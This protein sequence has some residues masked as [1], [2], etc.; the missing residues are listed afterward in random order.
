MHF[1]DIKV[2]DVRRETDECVS[3]AFD[4]PAEL[5]DIFKFE[6]GQNITIRKDINGEELRRS[7]SICTSPTDH[8]IRVAIKAVDGGRFSSWANS[9]LKPGD[10]L[11]LMPPTGRFNTRLDPSSR[12]KYLAFAAGSG[13]TPI[14]SI[15]KTTLQTEPQSS[16]TLVY[17]NRYRRSIIFREE[18]ESLK[19]KYLDRFQLIHILSRE[20]PENEVLFGR[21]DAAKC[22]QLCGQL[23]D[24]EHY[25]HAFLCG[26]ENMIFSVR[27][28]LLEQGF[29]KENIHYELFTAPGSTGKT[30][31]YNR[32]TT[33]QQAHIKV[34]IDG[35]IT[36]FDLPA[37]GD[38][39]LNAAL[40]HGADLPFACKG[41]VCSTCRARLVEGK[42]EM[43][44]NYALEQEEV[45]AGFILTCQS[46]PVTETVFVDFDQR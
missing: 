10:T 40:K 19:N 39:I 42:V 21:I 20:E 22:S 16:F 11:E 18:L 35:I 8:E 33:G 32:N 9:H 24:P 14:I 45:D 34:K 3:V 41:G 46:H 36:H 5:K 27:D 6:Q 25:H 23:L 7:Y 31:M 37:Q 26:P 38:T 17:G 1:Y 13:I 43:D 44:V 15:I 28:Y 12:K 4:I 30:E 2:K 29:P